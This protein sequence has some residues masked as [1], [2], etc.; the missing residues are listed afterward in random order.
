MIPLVPEKC[1]EWTAKGGKHLEGKYNEAFACRCEIEEREG[2]DTMRSLAELGP[3]LAVW[4]ASV[5]SV[6]TGQ[7]R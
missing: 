2:R 1:R 7:P 4:E 6:E 5:P 3:A